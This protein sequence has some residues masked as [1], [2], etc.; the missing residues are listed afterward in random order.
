MTV[1]LTDAA[2]EVLDSPHTAVI[3]TAN[4]D[5]RPQSSVIFVK[6]DG[7]SHATPV[8]VVVVGSWV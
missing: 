1:P 4:S 7:R 8:S 3:A 2:R 6:R 5:G